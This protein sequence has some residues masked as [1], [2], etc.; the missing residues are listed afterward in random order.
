MSSRWFVGA[1]ALLI[2]SWLSKPWWMPAFGQYLV[3][4][5]QPRKAEIAVVLAGDS[6]G[7]RVLKG[8]EL[9]RDGFVP[10]VLVSG[11]PGMY[12]FYESEL[13]VKFAAGRG[14]PA[15]AF[16]PL[17]IDYHSTQE[18]AHLIVEELK[19]R[20]VRSILLVTSNYHT[21][22]SARVWRYIAPWLDICVVA[23]HDKYFRRDQWWLDRES[24]KRVLNEWTKM[25]AFMVDLFPPPGSEPVPQP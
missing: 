24:A 17:H 8:A 1:L 12:G 7:F 23:A 15:E 18:E 19:R 3:H 22:R 2:V 13:A 16:E 5:E 10:K 20:K 11:P 25:L 14:F 21:R 4:A 9:Q 6:W